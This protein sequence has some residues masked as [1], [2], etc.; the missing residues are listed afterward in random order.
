VSPDSTVRTSE[1][2]D[3]AEGAD[4][5]VSADGDAADL[6][7]VPTRRR[8]VLAGIAALAVLLIAAASLTTWLYLHS[9]RPGQ[10]ANPAATQAALDAAKAGTIAAWSYSP[11]SLDKDLQNAKTHL[12]GDFLSY[13]T[14]FTDSV[15]RPAVKQEHVATTANV[16][17]AA[18]SEINPDSATVLLFVNQTTTSAQRTEPSTV[19]SIVMVTM[20]KIDGNWLISAL[21]PV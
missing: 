11:D 6:D 15:V 5:G 9:Y 20:N 10:A 12:T 4:C 7:K 14:D 3:A 19:S 21:N 13:Y 8:W 16:V 2:S 1:P 18:V 17:R